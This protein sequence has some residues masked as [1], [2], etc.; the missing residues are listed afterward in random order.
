MHSWKHESRQ[1]H[2]IWRSTNPSNVVKAAHKG[3]ENMIDVKA[4]MSERVNKSIPKEVK[5]DE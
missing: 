2:K 5:S 4:E 3:L 1:F